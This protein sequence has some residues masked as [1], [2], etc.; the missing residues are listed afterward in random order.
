MLPMIVAG[1][2]SGRVTKSQ[3][4]GQFWGFFF[5]ID[6]ALYCTAFGI[7]TAEP[8]E[9]LFGMMSG[10]GSRNSVLHLG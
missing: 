8:I 3:G 4:K 5:P 2:S 6:N 10:L 9:M 7:H 1:Y